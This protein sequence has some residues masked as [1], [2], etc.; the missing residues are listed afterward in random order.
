MP[1]DAL[2][3][4]VLRYAGVNTQGAS[5]VVQYGTLVVAWG[6]ESQLIEVRNNLLNKESL[7]NLVEEVGVALR[8]QLIPDLRSRPF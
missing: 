7:D 1:A 8:E 3:L 2:Q 6:L 5:T 4:R